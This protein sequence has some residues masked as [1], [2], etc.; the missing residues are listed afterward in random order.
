MVN[1]RR[2]RRLRCPVSFPSRLAVLLNASDTPRLTTRRRNCHCHCHCQY[3]CR[4]LAIEVL[5]K[6]GGRLL[7]SSSRQSRVPP[8]SHTNRVFHPCSIPPIS[9]LCFAAALSQN[10]GAVAAAACC[11]SHASGRGRRALEISDGNLGDA[12]TFFPTPDCQRFWRAA[13]NHDLP[14]PS[15]RPR[16]GSRTAE[17]HPGRYFPEHPRCTRPLPGREAG[18]WEACPLLAGYVRP[19]FLW[20]PTYPHLD[21]PSRPRRSVADMLLSRPGGRQTPSN[22]RLGKSM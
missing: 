11:L 21:P 8:P 9:S 17:R 12:S 1:L 3:H 10:A 16:R 20:L 15:R 14:G 4:C 18:A 22:M 7:V 2:I 6:E 19:F 5:P 13:R